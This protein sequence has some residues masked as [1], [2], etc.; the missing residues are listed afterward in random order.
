MKKLG[1]FIAVLFLMC[2]F[3]ACQS[4]NEITPSTAGKYVFS[5]LK[6]LDTLDKETFRSYFMSVDEIKAVVENID[7]SDELKQKSAELKAAEYI[8]EQDQIY[9][10]NIQEAMDYYIYWKDIEYVYYEY[11]FTKKTDVTVYYGDLYFK[12]D[13][14][15]FKIRIFTFEYNGSIGL[16]GLGTITLEEERTFE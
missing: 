9:H 2:F 3:N 15:L 1:I 8:A 13:V 7:L 16:L 4:N 14:Q 5:I 6:K 12:N 10:E 11:N